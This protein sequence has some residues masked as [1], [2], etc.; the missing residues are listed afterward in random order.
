MTRLSARLAAVLLALALP[1]TTLATDYTV[2]PGST[3]G[4]TGT[5]QG[6]AFHGSFKTWQ[7][8]IRYDPAQLAQAKFDVTVQLASV[9]VRDKDQQAALP[10]ADFF[11]V[12]RHPS[13]RF[14]TTGLHAVGGK[15]V[16]DG[17]LTLRGVSKPVR[18]AVTFTPNGNRATLDVSSVLKRLDFG[19][20]RGDF[21]D[22]SVIGADV[23]VQAHLLLQAR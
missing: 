23:T 20:G 13:A 9:A 7:A 6:A 1:A 10:G 19:V 16:A 5:F 21:A 15:V 11:D 8:T 18:L 2:Q 4:F 22:T 12:A 14:V 3:L 17:T